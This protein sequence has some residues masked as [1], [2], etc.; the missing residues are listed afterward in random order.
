MIRSVERGGSLYVGVTSAMVVAKRSIGEPDDYYGDKAAMHAAE[1]EGC[2]RLCLDWLAAK[3]GLIPEYQIPKH[4]IE[5][6]DVI[7]WNTVLAHAFLNFKDFVRE[8]EVEPIGIEQEDFSKTYGLVGHI[9][10]PC[11]FTVPIPHLAKRRRV[12]GPIDLKFVETVLESHRLQVRCYGKLDGMKGGTMG[13]IFHSNRRTGEWNFIPVNLN[14]NLHDV[15]AV[16]LCAK[17]WTWG[18]TKKGV[19]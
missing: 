15:Q 5:H 11:Y 16:S 14:E 10:L 4:P 7:R 2:H 17:I 9:D 8:Y 12:R 13:G 19:L 1:G 18:Q 6:D 3:H